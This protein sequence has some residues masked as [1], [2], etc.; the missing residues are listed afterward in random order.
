MYETADES[1][2]IARAYVYCGEWVGDC[3]RLK[4]PVTG[5]GCGNVEFLYKPSRMNGPRDRRLDFYICSSCGQ[6]SVIDWP[7][8]EHAI[9]TALSIRPMPNSRNWYPQDHPVAV[10]FRIPHGQTVRD[11]L[12]ENEEH[13]L[14]NEPLK[15]LIS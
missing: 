15:G 7:E 10:N 6:Q 11:L 14:N 3:P 8:N 9:L 2:P 13:G 4:D 1:V 5:K 12:D